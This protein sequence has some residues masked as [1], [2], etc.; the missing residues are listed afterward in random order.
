MLTSAAAIAPK[1][2]GA[3]GEEAGMTELFYVQ[4]RFEQD[5]HEGRRETVGWIEQRGAKIG[6]RVELKGEDGLWTV[7]TA[8]GVAISASKLRAKQASDRA[9]LPSAVR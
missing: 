5:T 3:M 1:L 6:A 4:C 9:S 7:V 2:H 8:G